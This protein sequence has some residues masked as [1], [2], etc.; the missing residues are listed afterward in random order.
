MSAKS[1]GGINY[2]IGRN[3]WRLMGDCTEGG[4]GRDYGLVTAGCGPD[5]GRYAA[6]NA[7]D[8]VEN[9][10]TS[11]SFTI[12]AGCSGTCNNT[13]TTP[14]TKD[15]EATSYGN[16][17]GP[18]KTTTDGIYTF[19]ASPL[20]VS[21]KIYATGASID[22]GLASSDAVPN[23]VASTCAWTTNAALTANAVT[24]TGLYP[25]TYCYRIKDGGGNVISGQLEFKVGWD[26]QF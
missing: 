18:L 24:L 23:R 8:G 10:A 12:A 20:T 21:V 2:V 14:T 11:G 16:F 17:T 22:Y 4:G 7:Y 3:I 25:G 15:A 6:D 19:M 1:A 9:T 5:A 26:V 13:F